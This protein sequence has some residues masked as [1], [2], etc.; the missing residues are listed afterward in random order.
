MGRTRHEPIRTCAGCRG[1]APKAALVRLVRGPDGRFAL[2]PTGRAPG[3]GAYLHPD[4]ACVEAARRR[5]ALERS[6]RAGPGEGVWERLG[7]LLSGAEAR[8]TSAPEPERGH[9]G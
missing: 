7:A 9:P 3:R 8:G 1:Q 6:L 4:A 2:D 5:R